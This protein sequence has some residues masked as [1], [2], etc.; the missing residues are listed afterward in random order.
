MARLEEETLSMAF[1]NWL[2]PEQHGDKGHIVG[3]ILQNFLSSQT[4]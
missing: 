4:V 3:Y 1:F 2:D